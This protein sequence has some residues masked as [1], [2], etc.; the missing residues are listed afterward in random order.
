MCLL[1]LSSPPE[2]LH[3]WCPLLIFSLSAPNGE[4]CWSKTG[5][6]QIANTNVIKLVQNV[7]HTITVERHPFLTTRDAFHAI[8]SADFS[9][10]ILD[11]LVGAFI[12]CFT[13]FPSV[14][15]EN[16]R[17]RVWRFHRATTFVLPSSHQMRLP[18][19]N[20]MYTIYLPTSAISASLSVNSTYRLL[21]KSVRWVQEIN[22]FTKH[23]I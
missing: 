10:T 9:L 11:A 8:D 16:D 21:A 7:D 12:F 13:S 5:L 22:F 14:W 23:Y 1:G 15:N 4:V 20:L 3:H 17:S 18:S 2:L 6:N 19:F